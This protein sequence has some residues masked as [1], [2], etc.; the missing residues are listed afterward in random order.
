[1]GI[2]YSEKETKQCWATIP[3]KQG[4]NFS[5]EEINEVNDCFK[6]LDEK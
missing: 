1:M 2:L 6:K 5:S 3:E 4:N